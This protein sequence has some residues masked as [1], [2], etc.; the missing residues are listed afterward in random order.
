MFIKPRLMVFV[1]GSNFLTQLAKVIGVQFKSSK[2]P[3][4]AI[5]LSQELIAQLHSHYNYNIVRRYWFASYGGDEPYFEKYQRILHKHS[6]DPKLYKRRNAK[7]KGV[8]IGLTLAMMRNAYQEN[9][10]VALLVAGDKDYVELVDE[11]K[12]YGPRVHGAFFSEGLSGTLKVTCDHFYEIPIQTG[13]YLAAVEKHRDNIE[14]EISPKL[15]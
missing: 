7:E 10:D 14:A 13:Q 2:P 15:L 6:F 1:D 12:R 9:F 4:P 11:T 5:T 8:D 3:E